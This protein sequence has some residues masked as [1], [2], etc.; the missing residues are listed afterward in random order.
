[1]N[2]LDVSLANT[3]LYSQVF[4]CLCFTKHNSVVD[5]KN[6]RR[7]NLEKW[8]SNKPRPEK[9]KSFISQ[10]INNVESSFGE[11]AARRLEKT[12]G[13]PDKYLDTE[14]TNACQGSSG[15]IT[16]YPAL[17][18]LNMD[19]LFLVLKFASKVENMGGDALQATDKI[20]DAGINAINVGRRAKKDK[21]E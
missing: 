3:K 13:M 11:K 5:I 6:V 7:R 9:E 19:Q 14:D 12:Y 4:A 15:R 1:M 2:T 16:D 17:D 18:K 8:F 21:G 10:L 20:V